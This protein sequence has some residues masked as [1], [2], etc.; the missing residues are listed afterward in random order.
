MTKKAFTH[1]DRRYVAG[2]EGGEGPPGAQGAQGTE[3][4]PG[5]QGPA[6]EEGAAGAQGP[7]GVNAPQIH[8]VAALPGDEI[9]EDDDFC[10]VIVGTELQ[11]I[12]RKAG[13]TWS[14][15]VTTFS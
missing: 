5:E 3:G 9:G 13:G 7:A 11:S 10:F 4:P 6:G 12:G 14:A 8:V 15:I 1:Y 2:P